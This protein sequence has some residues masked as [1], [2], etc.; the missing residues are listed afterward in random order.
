MVEATLHIC[1]RHGEELHGP[2]TKDISLDFIPQ[3][4]TRLYLS[5]EII[6]GG[7]VVEGISWFESS[8]DECGL[9][10][11]ELETILADHV[12]FDEIE[13]RALSSGWKYC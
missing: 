10:I 1:I 6:G 9:T 8:G 7:L 12:S 3:I 11:V 2:L 13:R 5:T 4:G